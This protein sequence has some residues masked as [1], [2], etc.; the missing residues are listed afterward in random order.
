[1]SNRDSRCR[2]ADWLYGIIEGI[3]IGAS[4]D[5]LLFCLAI[6]HQ[7]Q[8]RGSC[9]VCDAVAANRA[10]GR[11]LAIFSRADEAIGNLY[12]WVWRSGIPITVAHFELGVGSLK[13]RLIRART[14]VAAG[15]DVVPVNLLLIICHVERDDT[16][17]LLEI[18]HAFGLVGF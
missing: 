2:N 6:N 10:T 3:A 14:G 5:V 7:H 15:K 18:M 9:Y 4:T 13:V 12:I 11:W 17:P 16:P 1:M 8:V